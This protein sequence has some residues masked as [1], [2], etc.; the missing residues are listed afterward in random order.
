MKKTVWHEPLPRGYRVRWWN[1][2]KPEARSPEGIYC[3]T[4]DEVKAKKIECELKIQAFRKGEADPTK[5]PFDLL[6]DYIN[7]PEGNRGEPFATATQRKK[8]FAIRPLVLSMGS[9]L[10]LTPH[11][12]KTHASSIANET[13]RSMDLREIRAFCNWLVAHG[14]LKEAPFKYEENGIQKRIHI[15]QGS[16][17][18]TK[19]EINEIKLLLTKASPG[20]RL[21]L[22][23]LS[24]TGARKNEI[25]MSRWEDLDLTAG[26]WKILAENSKSRRER[27][28]P[29]D[30]ALVKELLRYKQLQSPPNEFVHSKNN[31]NTLLHA[32]AK[33]CGITKNV[34]PHVFRHS[35]ASHW[36]GHPDIAMDWLGW[37]S[38]EMRRRYTHFHVED[39]RRAAA[40]GGLSS[41]LLSSPE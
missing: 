2:E 25:L 4:F 19:L 10:E 35:F 13:T 39:L 36:T 8:L 16:R 12:I 30:P 20:F 3:E 11:K 17:R 34:T 23:F 40:S 9:V 37:K 26:T 38:E 29:L 27:T 6:A 1:P 28:I 15:P 7:D 32:L 21:R 22:L 24:L 18:E 14:H 5:K 33:R 41:N 31:L